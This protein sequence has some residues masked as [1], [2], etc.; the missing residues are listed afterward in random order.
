M[1]ESIRGNHSHLLLSDRI[2]I[3]QELN[4]GSTFYSIAKVLHKDPTTISKEVTS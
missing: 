3:E 4:Q 1:S 2:Y